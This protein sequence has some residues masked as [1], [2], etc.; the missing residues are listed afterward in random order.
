MIYKKSDLTITIHS[1]AFSHMSQ[2]TYQIPNTSLSIE[3]CRFGTLIGTSR[4]RPY[5]VN[6]KGFASLS[7]ALEA[8]NKKAGA[9]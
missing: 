7:R 1:W 8:L 5:A 6:N 4:S 3:D 2:S 9:V